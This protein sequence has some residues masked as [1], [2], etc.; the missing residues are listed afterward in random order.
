MG[1]LGTGGTVTTPWEDAFKTIERSPRPYLRYVP[2]PKANVQSIPYDFSISSDFGATRLYR[3]NV[4]IDPYTIRELG[5]IYLVGKEQ[6]H[7]DHY[8]EQHKKHDRPRAYLV[9]CATAIGT[10]ALGGLL[11]ELL[12]SEDTENQNT[13]P[14]RLAQAANKLDDKQYNI[15]ISHSW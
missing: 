9:G 2:V 11:G 4:A 1:S 12:S 8:P 7:P 5:P 15:L 13:G 14:N 10:I 3:E 6:Y